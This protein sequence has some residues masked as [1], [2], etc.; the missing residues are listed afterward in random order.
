MSNCTSCSIHL[1]K[2]GLL[3]EHLTKIWI[4]TSFLAFAG[5]IFA[6]STLYNMSSRKN[7]MKKLIAFVRWMK[8][9]V[10]RCGFLT[11]T[12]KQKKVHCVCCDRLFTNCIVYI[13][14][15]LSSWLFRTEFPTWRA[16]P[17]KFKSILMMSTIVGQKHTWVWIHRIRQVLCIW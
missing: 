3:I 7:L 16:S 11:L 8:F 4:C 9:M 2:F 17:F 15:S 13:L 14:H 5:A 6:R 1:W 12:R 10:A